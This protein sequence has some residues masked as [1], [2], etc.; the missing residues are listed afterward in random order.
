[1][2]ISIINGDFILLDDQLVSNNCYGVE[3]I[4]FE[5]GLILTRQDILLSVQLASDDLIY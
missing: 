3:Y 2:V 5:D 4:N 1:M